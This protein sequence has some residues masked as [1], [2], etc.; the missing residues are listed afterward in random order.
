MIR[1]VSA[2]AGAT[3]AAAL[4]LTACAPSSGL[5]GDGGATNAPADGEVFKIGVLA[6]MTSWAGAIGVDMQQGWEMF[7]DEYGDTAGSFTIETVWE[8]TA[9]DPDTALTKARKL[10]EEDGVD[11]VV[12]PVLASEGL[13]VGDYLTQAGV[14][15]LAQTAADDLTQRLASPLVVRTGA[16]TSS[17]P[18]FAGGDW[19]AKQG[20]RTAA[21]LCV[22]YAFGWESCGGFVS[23][24]TAAG[25]EVTTQ[26]WY[27]GDA[28]DLSSYVS[29]LASLDVDVIFVG[30]AGGTDSSNFFR[31]AND[32]GLLAKTP[33]VSNCCTTDQAIL[34]DVGD[35]ALGQISASN[36]AEGNDDPEVAAFVERYESAFGILPSSY[37]QG[38][39]ASAEILAQVLEASTSKPTGEA[40]VT[41]IKGVDLGDTII[42]GGGLD[43][44][45]S[46]VAPIFIREV[47]RRDDG[48]LVNAVIETYDDVSQFWTFDPEA[49]LANPPFTQEFQQQ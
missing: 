27:P 29:Q 8:D 49:Y 1:K 3:F 31:S 22:D 12:G 11:A 2:A 25:G 10:V 43:E 34:Q 33:I 23:A 38:M 19:A 15:N 40:L 9:S 17:Q 13:V 4:L 14:A 26:L 28:S 48:T 35:I 41:A 42:G 21:T 18:N 6:P 47:V 39:Y 44:L 7:W 24:F 5:A 46:P 37:A 32:F 30:S 36:W 16:V 45:G 20:Y